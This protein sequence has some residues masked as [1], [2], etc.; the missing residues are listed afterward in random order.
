MGVPGANHNQKMIPLDTFTKVLAKLKAEI[1]FLNSL[2]LYLWGEP[3]LHPKI[4]EL[5][6]LC[7]DQ[8]LATEFSSNLNNI[9][10]LDA[11]VEA[12]PDI[13]VVTSSGFGP[14]YEV[15]HTGGDFEKFK[16][17]CQVLR[18]KLDQ[19]KAETFVKYHYLVYKNNGGAEMDRA[20]AFSDSLGFQFVPI[21]ANIFPGR[22]H[23]YVVLGE[24]LPDAMVEANKHLLYDIHD[25]IR[26]A[27]QQK[28]K[29]CPVIKAF[30]TIKWDGSVMHCCNMTK[31]QVGTGYLNNTLE[32][33]LTLRERSG[34]CQRCQAH[35]VHRVFEV[36]GREDHKMSQLVPSNAEADAPVMA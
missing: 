1:P 3:L 24:P 31:P 19:H 4:G 12:D 2:A 6:R 23:D 17:N 36:N 25:Q 5:I 18:E 20:R 15:T 7:H 9:H 29:P 21:L 34:F 10:N 22:V 11:F 28:D 8:G 14:H 27:Q 26:W 30:P 13:L 33:L 16:K 35:G 32:G